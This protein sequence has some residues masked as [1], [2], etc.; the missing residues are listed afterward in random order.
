MSSSILYLSEFR[1]PHQQFDEILLIN[2][3]IIQY[4]KLNLFWIFKST[5]LFFDC[6][7]EWLPNSMSMIWRDLSM[8]VEMIK[9]EK[10]WLNFKAVISQ[11][12]LS[13]QGSKS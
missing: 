8:N 4:L 10:L 6:L 11:K 13:K 5:D 7:F 2:V 3:E 12:V 1:I 9:Y